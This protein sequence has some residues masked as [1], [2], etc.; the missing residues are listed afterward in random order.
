MGSIISKIDDDM[1][2]YDYLCKKYNEKEQ[3][4]YSVHYNYLI[5]KEYK[6]LSI[7]FEEYKLSKM[8]MN[9]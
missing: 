6:K 1:D 4:L 9:F 7:S 3:K 8:G 2:M 5:D